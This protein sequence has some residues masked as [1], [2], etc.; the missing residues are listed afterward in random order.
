MIFLRENNKTSAFLNS[1]KEL[2]ITKIKIFGG[3]QMPI[4]VL[5]SFKMILPISV[6]FS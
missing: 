4:V 6:A 1:L 2:Q 5:I 3:T